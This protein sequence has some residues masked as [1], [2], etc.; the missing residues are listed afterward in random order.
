MSVIALLADSPGLYVVTALIVGLAIGSFL[1][2]VIYRLPVML[3][4]QW[5]EQCAEF[6]H[7]DPVPPPSLRMLPGPSTCSIHRLTPA[8][9]TSLPR[10]PP[11]SCLR[12]L[13]LSPTH[14][15]TSPCRARPA[16]TARPRLPRCRTFR[17]SRGCSSAAAARAAGY[18]S[19]ALS[20]DRGANQ[21]AD[22]CRGL[23]VR[24]LAGWRRQPWS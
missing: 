23:E 11:L 9:C 21:R 12:R 19:R 2:V 13:R 7:P 14:P 3:E 8:R 6:A 18:G 22:C 15:L 16:H 24:G 17:C 4:R 20:P 10:Q 1:N 5:R